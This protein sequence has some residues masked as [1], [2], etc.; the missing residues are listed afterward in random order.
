MDSKKSKKPGK[1]VKVE[2][3]EKNL[4]FCMK[5]PDPEH[6][7]AHDKDEPCDDGR[8]GNLDEN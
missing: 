3:T 1:K 8:T 7:R 6:S 2:E 5:A 4:P